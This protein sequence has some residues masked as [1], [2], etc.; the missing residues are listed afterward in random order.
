MANRSKTTNKPV[1]SRCL[2]I[3]EDGAICGTYLNNYHDDIICYAC[4]HRFAWNLQ[5][6]KLAKI[7]DFH[8][9]KGVNH[10]R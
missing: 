2:A 3:K 7:E 10:G 4:R 8:R 6:P 5:M 9:Q 1:F